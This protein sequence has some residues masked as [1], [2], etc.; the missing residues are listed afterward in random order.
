MKTFKKAA[1]L[2]KDK[3]DVKQSIAHLNRIS[4]DLKERLGDETLKLDDESQAIDLLDLPI[5]MLVQPDTKSGLQ[6]ALDLASTSEDGRDA[7]AKLERSL[8]EYGA[9]RDTDWSIPA[10]QLLVAEKIQVDSLPELSAQLK[11]KIPSKEELAK[12]AGTAQA[13]EFRPLTELYTVADVMLQSEDDTR[14]HIGGEL[15]DYLKTVAKTI[16][17]PELDIAL[18]AI[19]MDGNES[20]SY[21]LQAIEKSKEPGVALTEDKVDSCLN[22]VRSA[23]ASGDIALSNRALKL[24]LENGPTNRRVSVGDAFALSPNSSVSSSVSKSEYGRIGG[25]DGACQ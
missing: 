20:L 12:A 2:T 7:L 17:Q 15:A 4:L 23:L 3:I 1:E 5:A 18:S 21:F 13:S 24:A 19:L 16:E 14:K 8:R 25:T 9:N 11:K 6:M 22:I 10:A